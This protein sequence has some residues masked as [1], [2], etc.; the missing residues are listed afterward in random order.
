[1]IKHDAYLRE[2]I[3]KGTIA[4]IKRRPEKVGV[5]LTTNM[6]RFTNPSYNFLAGLKIPIKQLSVRNYVVFL[7]PS[8][9]NKPSTCISF[10]KGSSKL[11]L[12]RKLNEFAMTRY[13]KERGLRRVRI[14]ASSCRKGLSLVRFDKDAFS[15][16]YKSYQ[17]DLLRSYIIGNKKCVNLSSIMSDPNFLISDW[18]IVHFKSVF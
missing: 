9:F 10:R 2:P 12:R 3:L 14:T 6:S 7:S 16:V 5:E 1:M 13:F 18:A 4:C 17:L 11:V 8:K 15:G